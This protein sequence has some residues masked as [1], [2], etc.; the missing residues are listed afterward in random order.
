MTYRARN[1][2]LAVALAVVA[3]LLTGFYVTNYKRTVQHGEHHVSVYVATKDIPAGTSGADVQSGGYLKKV[4]VPRR[5][6]VPGAITQPGQLDKYVAKDQ[7]NAGEQ[8][9]VRRFTTQANSGPRAQLKGPLRAIQFS[10]TQSQVLAG[11][12]KAGDHVDVVANL[13][14]DDQGQ[15]SHWDRVVL[16]DL[17]VLK[18]PEAPGATG[19]LEGNQQQFSLMLAATDTQMPKLWF[20]LKNADANSST[21]GGWALVLRPVVGDTD[22]P[23][24]L[25]WIRTVVLDG[26][27][28]S[29]IRRAINGGLR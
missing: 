29:Q 20:V 18:A 14:T 5:A 4:D 9:S 27:S 22:S 26:M 28:R 1:I 16:R 21:D 19:K 23:E 15:S 12:L 3:A 17:V 25:E 24:A 11:T 7:V 8:V 6:R 2:V 13:K 10:G